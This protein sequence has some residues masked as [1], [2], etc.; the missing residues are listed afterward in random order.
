MTTSKTTPRAYDNSTLFGNFLRP[1][2]SWSP[3]NR[4]PIN[5]T[6][7]PYVI[8]TDAY[9]PS[10]AEGKYSVGVFE[11][12]ASDPAVTVYA[13]AGSK[14]I[15]DPDSETDIPSV[16]IPHWPASATPATGGDGHCDIVDSTT[17]I[18]HSF[19]AL[20]NLNGVWCAAQYAWTRIDG[21]G[22]GDPAHHYQGARA[23]A[24]APIGGLIRKHEVNDNESDY[25]HVLAMSLTF[26]GLG[27]GKD[28]NTPT[29][30]Y[31]ATNADQYAWSLNRGQ[32][33]EG[34]LVMLPPDFDT[35]TLCTH[36]LRKVANTLQKFGARV[37]D[38]N[39]GTPFYIFVENGSGFEL[40]PGG[41]NQNVANDLHRLRAA[42]RM[43]TGAERWV[44]GLPGPVDVPAQVPQNVLSM[45]GAWRLETE[46][47]HK[48]TNA[49]GAAFDTWSQSLEFPASAEPIKLINSG[50]RNISKVT[51]AQLVPGDKV[52]MTAKA[53][54]RA[55]LR[56]VVWGWVK[57]KADPQQTHDTGLLGDGQSRT[58]TL[59]PGWWATFYAESGGGNVPA[60]VSGT[61]VKVGQ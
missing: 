33:P 25:G 27:G 34:S 13:L 45:R 28:S 59:P 15:R 6:F 60:T 17:G 43:A 5:P 23:A 44:S 30:V 16:I 53:T 31:P 7:S 19:W 56:M 3:W 26:S 49:G 2:I 38:Q 54:G 18:V 24:V 47:D 11:A 10:I 48:S 50:G 35:S 51:W 12:L 57:G 52:T 8:P 21:T 22:W 46:A 55:K 29:Y 4:R 9:Y 61:L 20:K 58:I 40:M 36:H 41:W 14:G 39:D 32:I 42:L 1:F 37:V